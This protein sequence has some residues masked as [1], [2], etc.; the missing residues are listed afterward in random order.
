MYG[1]IRSIDHRCKVKHLDTKTEVHISKAQFYFTDIQT[2]HS[3]HGIYIY[4]EL[5]CVP[6]YVCMLVSLDMSDVISP[7]GECEVTLLLSWR[8]CSV[9]GQKPRP[10]I[11]LKTLK[12]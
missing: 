12:H 5:V 3:K 8:G 1:F 4:K 11:K 9:F 6:L 7:F 2:G 10:K